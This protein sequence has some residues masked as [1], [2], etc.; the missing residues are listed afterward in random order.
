MSVARSPGGGGASCS[1]PT[2]PSLTVP[3][4]CAIARVSFGGLNGGMRLA[5]ASDTPAGVRTHAANAVLGVGGTPAHKATERVVQ[6]VLMD[7]MSMGKV[8]LAGGP[9]RA[10]C[11]GAPDPSSAGMA[12]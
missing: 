1:T 3:R 4:Y 5:A 11:R 2:P 10:R 12:C 9:P 6:A 8:R 7:A